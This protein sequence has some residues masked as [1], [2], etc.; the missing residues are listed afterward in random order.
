LRVVPEDVAPKVHTLLP[1]QY[2]LIV[3]DIELPS[4]VFFS[5][6][7]YKF[8]VGEL[9]EA[10]EELSPPPHAANIAVDRRAK[11]SLKLAVLSSCEVVPLAVIL[12]PIIFV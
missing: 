5:K 4:I 10:D 9:V 12:Y 1:S 7:A 11:P 8:N 3:P 6:A 2:P